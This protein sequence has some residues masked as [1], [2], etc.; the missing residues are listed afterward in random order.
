MHEYSGEFYDDQ[1]AGSLRSA[2]EIVPLILDWIQPK[3]VL[4]VGCGTGTWLSVFQQH[5]VR[6]ILGLDG[7]YVDRKR[8]LI[9]IDRFRA[10][11]L[12]EPPNLSGEFD[13]VMSLEVAEHLPA[14]HADTFI[15]K[16]TGFGPAVL[17]SAAIPFQGGEH[18]VNEQW[19]DYWNAKFVARNFVPID[20]IRRRIWDDENVEWWYAQNIILYVNGDLIERYPR[21]LEE[22]A[23][24]DAPPRSLVHPRK[25]LEDQASTRSLYRAV[26][27]IA[28]QVPAGAS[29][30]SIDDGSL[31]GLGIAG[32]LAIPFGET[33][34]LYANLSP[35]DE[36]AIHDFERQRAA[37]AGYAVLYSTAFWWWEQ[38]AEFR[39]HVLA[40][41]R[42][43]LNNDRMMIF[44]LTGG[45]GS[46]GG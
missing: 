30:I 10:C 26:E 32:R 39:T 21:L 46:D 13:L 5:G 29:F 6:E 34:G 17:F 14:Q 16:L 19:P 9:P 1:E 22:R 27:E 4:D 37:G 38:L 35:D 18:H 24:S 8:L 43:V 23:K 41:Y 44:D 45:E 36:T 25:Y 40:N 12:T 28:A 20:C 31:G 33:E 7:D 11:D 3:S 2:R 42:C 15:N